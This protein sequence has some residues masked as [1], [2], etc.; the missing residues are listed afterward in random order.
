MNALLKGI[1]L[2]V[3]EKVDKKVAQFEQTLEM[4]MKEGTLFH[5]RETAR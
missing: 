4:K 1:D 3:Q 2:D 5:A